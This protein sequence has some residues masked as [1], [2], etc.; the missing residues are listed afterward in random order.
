MKLLLAGIAIG[1]LV[2]FGTVLAS[3]E[4]DAAPAPPAP[5]AVAQTS[6]PLSAADSAQ[7]AEVMERVRR[8]YV[9]AIE[10]PEL[11]DDALRG[12]VSGLDPYSSYLDADEYADL[13][14]STAGT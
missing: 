13:R 4:D 7:L 14:V 11:I 9:D 8:E 12:L 6:G 1:F 5:E 2:T 10:H 3:R